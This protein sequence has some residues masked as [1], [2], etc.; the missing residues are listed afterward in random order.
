MRGSV[1]GG[2]HARQWAPWLRML[3]HS[4][5]ARP[6]QATFL[7]QAGCPQPAGALTEQSASS[8]AADATLCQGLACRPRR[9]LPWGEMR[10]RRAAAPRA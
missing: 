8:N 1:Q 5:A 6:M 9:A 7:G 10:S 3:L 2:R 4:P